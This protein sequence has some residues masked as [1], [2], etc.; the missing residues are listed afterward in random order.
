VHMLGMS[1]QGLMAYLTS[2]RVAEFVRH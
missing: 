2:Y 1:S